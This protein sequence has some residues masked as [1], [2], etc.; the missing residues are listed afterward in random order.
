MAKFTDDINILNNEVT[1]IVTV[2]NCFLFT[3]TVQAVVSF[4][5]LLI[6]IILACM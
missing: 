2:F 3:A 6:H 4:K 5:H 1:S